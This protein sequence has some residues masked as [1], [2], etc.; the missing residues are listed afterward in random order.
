MNTTS[1]LAKKNNSPPSTPLRHRVQSQ[2]LVAPLMHR[3]FNQPALVER[4]RNHVP[5]PRAETTLPPGAET[6]SQNHQPKPP[7]KT[8]KNS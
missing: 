3:A 7:A 2:S 5:K 4:S 1:G 6:T 8:S